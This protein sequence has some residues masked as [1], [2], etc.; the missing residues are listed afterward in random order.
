MDSL[1]ILPALVRN[2]QPVFDPDPLDHQD[3]IISLDLADRFDLVMVRIN[4]DLAR[5]QRTR[6]RAGQSAT[7]RCDDVVER[8]RV[9]RILLRVHA[10]VLGDLGMDAENHGLL[11]G[12]KVGKPLR[13]SEPL[14]PHP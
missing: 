5:F 4:F 8:R 14:D 1:R 7:R 9:R 6:E 12:G 13:A 11:L 3:A 2:L 10:V